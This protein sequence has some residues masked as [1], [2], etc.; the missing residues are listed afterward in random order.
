VGGIVGKLSFDPDVRLSRATVA[1]MVDA[2]GHRGA[3]A[4][5][6]VG[7]GIA[8]GWRDAAPSMEIAR[9]E[10]GRVRA[11]ADAELTNGAALRRQLERLGHVFDGR[12]DA[13]VMAHAYEEW[14]DACVDRFSGPFACA[15][16]DDGERRLLLA[17]DHM[18]IRPLCYAL[19]HGDGVV[20]ASE[21]KA[22]LQDPSV[23][24]ECS[25]EAIDVYLTL[26]YV[27][28]PLTMYRRVSRLEAAH[29]LVVEG[30]RLTTR[31]YWDL[32]FGR[33]RAR[34][35]DEVLDVL[36]SLLR[37]TV[38]DQMRDAGT[39]VLH[40]GGASS[41]AVA[42]CTPRGRAALG[43]AVERRPEDLVRIA[44]MSRQLGLR[45]ELDLAVPGAADV[46]RT[47]AW[48]MDEPLADPAAVTQYFV[49]AAARRRMH[50]A[51][52]GL[53]GAALWAGYRR[54]LVE[55]LEWEM[56]SMLPGP[57]AR[58]G[59]GVGRML[60]GAVRGARA[61]AHL[62]LPPAGACATKH[63]HG[64]FHDGCRRGMYTRRF[65]WQVREAD[66]FARH[67]DVYRRC[68]SNDPL[69]RALYV[70]A[71]TW[72]PDSR[73]AIADRAAAAAGLALR[74]PLL[75]RG[76][77]ELSA[78]LPS[79]LKIQGATGMYALRRLAA[80]H[81]PSA[82]LPPVRRTPAAR[83][84]LQEALESLVPA[85]LL[86]ERFDSRGIFSRP[87]IRALWDEHAGGRRDHA[88]RLWAVLML[89]LWF[90]EFI[91]GDAAAHPPEYALLVRAA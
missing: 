9:T 79:R 38:A 49:F 36:E 7:R 72:L 27:P 68:P 5:T 42:A 35:E 37:A 51:V 22:L 23:D 47:L 1:R 73:L 85:T 66:P 46:A 29:T 16:W 61:L 48:H 87:A 56:R 54:H 24:R 52:T 34:D 44:E 21:I 58:V 30:R 65:A 13:E 89:E 55:R 2:V 67:V 75:D 15:I 80:R 32:P 12:T 86:H 19:L 43:V 81:V 90:R 26:G 20:F 53:G 41:S 59:G 14:G 82:L 18:G 84:W 3:H 62:A 76:I 91:D 77:V 11:A 78:S 83:P 88:H 17:R 71:R 10:T 69:A 33:G 40:S 74:H 8:L 28:S 63:A 6:W 4:A 57:L 50:A 70:D 39:G 64:F 25:P 60:G 31:Q 45:G